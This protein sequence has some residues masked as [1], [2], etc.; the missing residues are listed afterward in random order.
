MTPR[1]YDLFGADEGFRD[2]FGFRLEE[3]RFQVGH[4]FFGFVLDACMEVVH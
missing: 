2:G 1:W 4:V 3:G